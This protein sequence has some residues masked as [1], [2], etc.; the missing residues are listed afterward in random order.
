MNTLTDPLA[1]RM[2]LIFVGIAFS[3]LIAVLLMR[4]IRRSLSTEVSFS[5]EIPAAEGSP[6]FAVIQ[7]LKQQ[8][9]ELQTDRQAEQRRAKTSENISAAV[10]SNLSSGV[11][12]LSPDGL[13]RQANPAARQIL[14][15]ASPVGV[16]AAQIFR[17]AAL[18]RSSGRLGTKV[19]EI[20]Q[21]SLRQMSL[22]Q[23]IDAQYVTPAGERRMLDITLTAVRSPDGQVL[24]AACLIN[25]ETEVAR[26]R[27]QQELRGEMSSEKA[28]ELH[29]SVNAISAYALRLNASNDPELTRQLA[30]DIVE[31]AAHLDSTI[32]GFLSGAGAARAASGT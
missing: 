1:L 22:Q 18:V 10:L 13:V 17:D 27:Q 31:E 6:L 12:F 29:N 9:Y 3:F 25:N 20:I 4:R 21:E 19:A 11:M 2:G 24:G 30:G 16:T 8:K 14:G 15:F 28:L 23:Q 7:Q 32:G 26:I 5:T